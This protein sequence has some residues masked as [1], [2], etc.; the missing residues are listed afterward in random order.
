MVDKLQK[1]LPKLLFRISRFVFI[2]DLV[3]SSDK[4][5]KFDICKQHL[6]LKMN[7]LIRN[8]LFDN[9]ITDIL[10]EDN[11]IVK[12]EKGIDA[13]VD[14]IID[15]TG[16]AVVPG[17]INA[18]THAAMTLFRG[19]ADDMKL[20]EWL[21]QKIW[22]YEAKLTDEQVYW[23]ARLACLEMIKSGTTMFHDMYWNS[24]ATIQ[25]VID[26][27]IRGVISSVLFDSA[28]EEQGIAL[29][30]IVNKMLEKQQ[31]PRVQISIG[32]HSV[33]TN[34]PSLL[35]WAKAT[36]DDNNL[37]IHIHL[38]ETKIEVEN[39]K[40]AFGCTPVEYLEKLDVLGE[41]I[42]AA[43]SVWLTDHDIELLAKRGVKVVHNPASNMKLCS[44]I[45][46]RYK[47]LKAAGVT[48]GLGTDGCSSSNNLDMIEAMKLASL[49]CKA[50]TEDPTAMSVEETLN[51]A[52]INGAKIFN[53]NAGKIESGRL[54]DLCLVDLK[55]P[56]MIPNHHFLS[57]LIYASNGSC[58]DTVICN[59]KIL[60]ENRKV[61]DEN[62]IIEQAVL[63]AEQLFY[64]K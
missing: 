33:Y 11:Q 34:S 2:S 32:P 35:K 29:K 10:I 21:T 9:R 36:A 16:K 50:T 44:G 47:D 52:T 17:F 42:V 58:I 25:A 45:A 5:H 38:A 6:K 57:N 61:K 31:N 48:V 3:D 1:R 43:H 64:G 53:I 30:K 37:L 7:L 54:A 18:H 22:P 49:L 20:E 27:G 55:R 62:K 12:I 40:S 19:F 14:R 24:D 46:F 26:S 8:V 63:C 13:V 41:N 23:G 28:G 15:G 4:T 39:A 59:G 60:M 51:L 56:E